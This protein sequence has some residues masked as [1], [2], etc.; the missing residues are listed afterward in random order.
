MI[1]KISR[2]KKITGVPML[3]RFFNLILLLMIIINTAQLYI[4][5]YEINI[6]QAF[7]RVCFHGLNNN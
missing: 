4:L 7:L 2:C 1:H 6:S 5:T 3:F